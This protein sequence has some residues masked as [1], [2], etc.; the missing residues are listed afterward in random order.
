MAVF[1]LLGGIEIGAWGG[2]GWGGVIVRVT[3]MTHC[4]CAWALRSRERTVCVRSCRATRSARVWWVVSGNCCTDVCQFGSEDVY[5]ML[6]CVV[7]SPSRPPQALWTTTPSPWATPFSSSAAWCGPHRTARC[8]CGSCLQSRHRA[9]HRRGR[10]GSM[11]HAGCTRG[12][13]ARPC[14]HGTRSRLSS[15][16]WHTGRSANVDCAQC[17][18]TVGHYLFAFS[19]A[20]MWVSSA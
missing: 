2:E 1:L 6:C 20:C 15:P 14:V 4:G 12:Q 11:S 18:V 3:V 17:V 19:P 9:R 13:Q 8:C 10:P 16:L 5:V 7:P